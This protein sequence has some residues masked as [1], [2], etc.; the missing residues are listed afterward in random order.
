MLS[1]GLAEF[2]L[3]AVPYSMLVFFA[4]LS[5]FPLHAIFEGQGTRAFAALG[6]IIGL[7]ISSHYVAASYGALMV[8][9]FLRGRPFAESARDFFAGAGMVV[10][11]FFLGTPFLLPELKNTAGTIGSFLVG[12]PF[13]SAH[14]SD[15]SVVLS[16]INGEKLRFIFGYL[17]QSMDL[18]G[19]GLFLVVLGYYAELR[20]RRWRPLL[21]LLPY[22]TVFPVMLV[23]FFSAH[24]YAILLTVPLFLPAARGALF[25]TNS[26]GGV[27]W[28]RRAVMTAIGTI[29]AASY[30]LN[31][32]HITVPDTRTMAQHWIE[33]V[34]PAGEK[35]LTAGP[36]EGP[37][38]MMAKSQVERL[39]ERTRSLRHPR[40]IYYRTLLSGHPGGGYEI[41]YVK[42]TVEE[43]LDIPSRTEKAFQAQEFID[44]IK[45]GVAPLLQHGV[46]TV[47]ILKNW[48]N[49]ER[50]KR[51]I[52][53]LRSTYR[54]AATFEP[55]KNKVKGYHLE[56][57]RK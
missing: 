22:A 50:H 55:E 38:L 48:E 10:V 39:H 5:L 44:V 47:V 16:N 57:Y 1:S 3:Q 14:P 54:L 20:A 27:A 6:F 30:F 51:W 40:E 21:F 53:E 7:T 41:L 43:I 4:A 28:K 12:L 56:I 52:A 49:V 9:A 32:L 2:S 29:F 45:E 8:V 42:K 17:R 23:S 13:L 46:R 36:Y 34:V 35:V 33:Q 31:R 26:C 18:W 15:G 25:L 11:G 24:R 19:A 37:Q